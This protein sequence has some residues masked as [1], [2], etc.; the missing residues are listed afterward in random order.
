MGRIGDRQLTT[1]L[2]TDLSQHDLAFARS[3]LQLL[4]AERCAAVPRCY[5]T[6]TSLKCVAPGLS[7][8]PGSF[9]SANGGDDRR[10]DQ[11][12]DTRVCFQYSAIDAAPVGS[13]Q[14]KTNDQLYSQLEEDLKAYGAQS[15]E[16]TPP[17]LLAQ[18]QS[19]VVSEDV[20]LSKCFK[21]QASC[22]LFWT[23]LVLLVL[24]SM[25]T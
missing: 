7:Y 13:E 23:K 18:F 11:G 3:E 8:G 2:A 9:P 14:Y 20:V 16:V 4:L 19:F 10:W 15:V 1:L 22:T 25:P 12:D 17:L 21:R 6:R 5:V 24:G